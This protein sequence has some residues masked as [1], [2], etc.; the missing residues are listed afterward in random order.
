MTDAPQN[1]GKPT[2]PSSLNPLEAAWRSLAYAFDRAFKTGRRRSEFE[3]KYRST[4]DYFGYRSSAY[5]RDKYRRTLDLLTAW[6][7]G[8]A[9]ALE[10]G[11]SVGVFTAM[12]APRF[13]CVTAVDIAQEALVLAAKEVSGAGDVSY[14]RS[15]IAS[16]ALGSTFDVILCAEVLMY[17]REAEGPQVCAVLDRHL[18]P[19]GLIVE[20]TQ[21]DRQAGAPKF[22][23]GW[24]R[25]L[26]EHF[27][28]AHRERFDD[29]D[30]PYEIVGYTRR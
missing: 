16:L 29:P 20:V 15:D 25:I 13:T 5:E 30:R 10:I 17:V 1:P 7:T 19:G 12:L 26:G 2:G 24:D 4:G 8:T 9:S 28:I 22:F 21:Q 27:R 11:C 6:R 23:H 14:V 3:H 18:A